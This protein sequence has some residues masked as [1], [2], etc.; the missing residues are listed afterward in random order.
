MGNKVVP[1][2]STHGDSHPSL[3]KGNYRDYY[4]PFLPQGVPLPSVAM[5]NGNPKWNTITSFKALYTLWGVY[6][7]SESTHLKNN[8]RC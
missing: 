8:L 7:T 4:F 3:Y 2:H 5:P 1:S 6:K